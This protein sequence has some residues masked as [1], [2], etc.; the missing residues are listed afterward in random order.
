MI[1]IYDRVK[2]SMGPL[3]SHATGM[4]SLGGFRQMLT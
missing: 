4:K 3:P 1:S 2:I